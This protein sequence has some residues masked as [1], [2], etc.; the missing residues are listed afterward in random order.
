MTVFSEVIFRNEM[1][2]FDKNEKTDRLQKHR[3]RCA[4]L[5]NISYCIPGIM[6]RC[7]AG[8]TWPKQEKCK[9]AKK[10]TTRNRCMHYITSL[11]GHCDCVEAQRE[12][13]HLEV[14]KD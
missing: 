12:L 10:S 8:S 9:F 7:S 4:N 6:S 5:E 14:E 3:R 2:M 11:D 1:N 13:R